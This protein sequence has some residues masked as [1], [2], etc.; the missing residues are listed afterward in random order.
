MNIKRT[1]MTLAFMAV[2]TVM[3]YAQALQPKQDVKKG[4]WGYVNESGDWV[5]KPK[6]TV[7]KDFVKFGDNSFAIVEKDGK[8]GMVGITGE[9]V[10]RPKYAKVDTRLGS[11]VFLNNNGTTGIIFDCD[12]NKD[13]KIRDYGV[14]E[15]SWYSVAEYTFEKTN[16]KV[17][18]LSVQLAATVMIGETEYKNLTFVNFDNDYIKDNCGWNIYDESGVI[19]AVA[20]RG[21]N[22][23]AYLIRNGQLLAYGNYEGNGDIKLGS[24]IRIGNLNAY[25]TKSGDMIEP[26][27]DNVYKNTDTGK[28]AIVEYLEDEAGRSGF[29]EKFQFDEVVSKQGYF[30][31][32][33]TGGKYQILRL[34]GSGYMFLYTFENISGGAPSMVHDKY[35]N[36]IIGNNGKY[37]VLTYSGSMLNCEYDSVSCAVNRIYNAYKNGKNYVHCTSGSESTFE[38]LT[39]LD[40]NYTITGGSAGYGFVMVKN[41]K[42]GKEGVFFKGKMAIPAIYDEIVTSG[43]G[44]NSGALLVA[45]KGKVKYVYNGENCKLLAD[46]TRF[47]AIRAT[48]NRTVFYVGKNNHVGLIDSSTGKVI[49]PAVYHQ[50][51]AY[52]RGYHV[53][54]KVSGNKVVF[55]VYDSKG[56]LKAQKAIVSSMSNAIARFF[57]SWCGSF[58]LVETDDMVNDS[59]YRKIWLRK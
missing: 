24:M 38:F 26:L 39:E 23:N 20:V 52:G 47:D 56:T 43:V 33:R 55:Y 36:V 4:V 27:G 45:Y 17:K 12:N 18:T 54:G 58:F 32:V 31:L 40:G 37:G 51:M 59:G 6:Y 53:M 13:F 11:Y 21:G 9:E 30:Y 34:S 14:D 42:S 22:K 48:R 15:K 1:F 25:I 35:E 50:Y 8:V 46:G 3:V 2:S 29:N 7:A 41:T 19:A 16:L 10:L 28:F 44:L 5:V 57:N 49:V